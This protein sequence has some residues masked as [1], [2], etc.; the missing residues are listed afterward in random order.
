MSPGVFKSV[1]LSMT[2]RRTHLDTAIVAPAEDRTVRD[3]YR[4]DGDSA[5]DKTEAG[6]FDRY[7]HEFVVV[8]VTTLRVSTASID[9]AFE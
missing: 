5:F 7:C 8:H 4:S 2:D 3:E 9:R 1:G 6:L